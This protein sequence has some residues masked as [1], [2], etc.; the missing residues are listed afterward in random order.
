MGKVCN[1]RQST[2]KVRFNPESFTIDERWRGQIFRKLKYKCLR[3]G[4]ATEEDGEYFRAI[5]KKQ[6]TDKIKKGSYYSL[7]AK[8]YLWDNHDPV[9]AR[10]FL[11]K[12]I[13]CY[14]AKPAAYF[15]YTLSFFPR[16]MISLIYRNRPNRY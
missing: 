1:L 9:K 15:L 3:D 4:N 11:R 6:D 8:K 7:M 5:I 14:P 12:W 16:K 13:G 10:G 2:V